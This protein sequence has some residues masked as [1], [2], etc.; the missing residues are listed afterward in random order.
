MSKTDG[1]V[2]DVVGD[3]D[4]Q[5]GIDNASNSVMLSGPGGDEIAGTNNAV[6]NMI[7]L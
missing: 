3:A 4:Y 2:S 1:R 6:D 5:G 7:R